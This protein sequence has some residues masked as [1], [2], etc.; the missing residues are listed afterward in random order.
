MA[1]GQPRR[2]FFGTCIMVF[3]ALPCSAVFAHW[4][5]RFHSLMAVTTASLLDLQEGRAVDLQVIGEKVESLIGYF[6]ALDKPPAPP[7]LHAITKDGLRVALK[8]KELCN[9]LGLREGNQFFDL[10]DELAD[11]A[12]VLAIAQDAETIASLRQ[13]RSKHRSA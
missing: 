8:L 9:N 3:M 1:L 10:C 13:A 12:E 4:L 5:P 11:H 6:E 7:E 2:H